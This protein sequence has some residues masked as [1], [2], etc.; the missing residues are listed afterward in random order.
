MFQ[1]LRVLEAC[2]Q[3]ES[4][5][6]EVKPVHKSRTSPINIDPGHSPSTLRLLHTYKSANTKAKRFLQCAKLASVDVA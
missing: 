6:T 5:E 2:K 1:K 4:K 3:R